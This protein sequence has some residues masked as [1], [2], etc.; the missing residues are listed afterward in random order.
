MSMKT[1]HFHTVA[2]LQNRLH[3]LAGANFAYILLDTPTP[4]PPRSAVPV[5]R[6]FLTAGAGAGPV[7]GFEFGKA[8]DSSNI[9]RRTVALLMLTEPAAIRFSLL[10]HRVSFSF[11]SPRTPLPAD[12][13]NRKITLA[14]SYGYDDSMRPHH[15]RPQRAGPETIRCG[16]LSGRIRLR[17]ADQID[18]IEHSQTVTV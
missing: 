12:V 9:V 17:V 7:F 8:C 4:C 5:N 11:G 16:C 18:I 14:E 6:P 3:F 10:L 15:V 1:L 13:Q 2:F